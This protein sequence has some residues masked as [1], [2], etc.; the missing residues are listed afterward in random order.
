MMHLLLPDLPA[1]MTWGKRLG[2]MLRAG[3]CLLLSGGLGAGKTTLAQAIAA[4]LAIPVD[5]AVTSPSFSLLH[6]YPG[7]RLPLAHLDL[8]RLTGPD[9][10]ESSG[11]LEYLEPEQGVVVI[12]W[13]ERLGELM[14]SDCLEINLEIPVGGQ[15]RRLCL[16]AHGPLWRERLAGDVS[17][18]AHQCCSS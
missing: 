14:P 3:D 1:T 18:L 13:P 16:A 10:I 2:T 7:G 15:G 8:Y 5:V 4:G 6:Q 17:A 11:L 9:D 12:E